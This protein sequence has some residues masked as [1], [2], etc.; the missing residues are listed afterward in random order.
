M[1]TIAYLL[2]AALP[3]PAMMPPEVLAA[4]VEAFA[5]AKAM[6]DPRLI[7]PDCAA[8]RL[9]WAGPRSVSVR[10]GAP[11][12]QVFVAVQGESG[13]HPVAQ[14][15]EISSVPAVRRGDRVV[16]EAGG[17]GFL[18]AVEGVAETDAR[19]G[20]VMVK[21]GNKR[22]LCIVDADGHVKIR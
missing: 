7:L 22:L 14:T 9:E 12:W 15:L 17:E 13:V 16:V 18:V 21:A 4:Q 2:V 3:G 6:V 11:V 8:P 5:N 10:C 1:L 19:D 20:R